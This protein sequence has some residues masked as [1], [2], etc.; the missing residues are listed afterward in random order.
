MPL[1]VVSLFCPCTAD[2]DTPAV[3]VTSTP[4]MAEASAA[5]LAE[6]ASSPTALVLTARIPVELVLTPVTP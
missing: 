6:L 1:P 4:W 5:V 3:V 2:A